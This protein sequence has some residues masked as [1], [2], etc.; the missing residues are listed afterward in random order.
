MLCL[1]A[2]GS[3]GPAAAGGSSGGPG[4][5]PADPEPEEA[6]GDEQDPTCACCMNDIEDEELQALGKSYHPECFRKNYRCSVCDASL[7]TWY[8]EKDGILFCKADYADK[9]GESCQA[10]SKVITGPVM[11]AA[12][13]KFH[14]ECFRCTSCSGFI[15]DGQAYALIERSK[16]YCGDCYTR[17][18]ELLAPSEPFRVPH[19][20]QLVQLPGGGEDAASRQ[21]RLGSPDP[22]SVAV[23]IAEMSLNSEIASLHAGDRVLEVNGLPVSGDNMET[24]ERIINDAHEDVQLTIEHDPRP[25][26]PSARRL[27]VDGGRQRRWRRSDEGYLSGRSRQLRR[28][29]RQEKEE[30]SSSMP[31][32]LESSGPDGGESDTL[33]RTQ[34]FR[35][36]PKHQRI[37]RAADLVKG[38]L[39]GTGFFGKVFKVTHRTT[40]ETMVLKELYRVDE[41]AQSNFLK[42]VAVL[43][44]L[45]H[46]NVLG[47]IGVLYKERRLHLV[48]EYISG[49][50]LAALVH[51]A[52]EPLPWEQRVGF[53]RDIAA[54]MAYLHSRDIIHRDLNS[55]NCLV[56]EN[57]TVVVA[58]FGLA[59]IIT[60]NH[61]TLERR[62]MNRARR[63]QR[64]KRY[65]VVGNPYWMAPEMMRGQKY[66]EKVD[67]FSFGIVLCEIIGRV[68][69][70][71]DFLPRRSKDFGL[72]EAEFLSRFCSSC[73]MAFFKICCMCCNTDPD[74]RPAFSLTVEWLQ[75]LGLHIGVCSEPP[76]E[77]LAE[78]ELFA[79]G[80]RASPAPPQ[81]PPPPLLRTISET[82]PA[83]FYLTPPDSPSRTPASPTGLLTPDGQSP[84]PVPTSAL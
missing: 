72:D 75:T 25:V 9:F 8:F 50:S 60:E 30:R 71:P 52:S 77:L 83:Y 53:A 61:S 69:A 4:Q 34:S 43:R 81:L 21:I 40:G 12:E 5:P 29:G 15:E 7:A 58:D 63:L 38:D 45:D 33:A 16:L 78:L 26:P 18:M 6:A 79:S 20:I 2:G 36:P 22:G 3:G 74:L 35:V 56:R 17:R 42:E 37:F 32:I 14:P 55:H 11:E 41:E 24:I 13:H 49:G 31:R 73:P 68:A 84:P 62:K 57:R 70:D 1:G 64:K 80:G 47:F 76:A 46:P 27:S 54:G 19:S 39:L 67:I 59:R 10:C 51:N 48:T 66:D 28:P 23:R 82:P 44:S 65:T